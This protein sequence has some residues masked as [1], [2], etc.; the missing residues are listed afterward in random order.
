MHLG[1]LNLRFPSLLLIILVIVHINLSGDSLVLVHFRNI[2]FLCEKLHL[3]IVAVLLY[4]VYKL[5][6][7]RRD[8]MV[9]LYI[10]RFVT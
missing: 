3:D 10:A 8:F 5:Y 9:A 4:K 7:L 2:Y 6:L 1:K